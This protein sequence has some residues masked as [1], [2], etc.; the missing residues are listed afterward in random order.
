MEFYEFVAEEVITASVTG[1]VS[2]PIGTT[3][4]LTDVVTPDPWDE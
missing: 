3:T 1:T 4:G 2:V